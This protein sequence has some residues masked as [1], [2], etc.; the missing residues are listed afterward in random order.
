M[1]I[2]L[3]STVPNFTAQATSGQTINLAEL[4][5]KQVVLYFYPKDN[6]P[7]CTTEGQAFRDLYREFEDAGALVFG[8]SKDSLRTHENFKQKQAFP[9]ELISDSDE[10]LCR[11]FDVI[12]L[13]QMYGKQYE[14]IERST[15][16]ID[17][18]GVLRHEWRKV[19]VPGHVDQVL[20]A[21]RALA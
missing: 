1:S 17:A 20:E 10:S 5:G 2:E 13:K 11:L 4:A 9:F 19:K 3:G 16:V 21:V 14:G 6:T 18:Q 15:F 7:G 8:V 12:R